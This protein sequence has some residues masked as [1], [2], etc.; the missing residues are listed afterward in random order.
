[1]SSDFTK[2]NVIR[3]FGNQSKVAEFFGITRMAVSLWRD[4]EP[5]PKSRRQ[6]LAALRPKDFCL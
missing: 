2:E 3:Y 6:L 1:M 4:G 5:I